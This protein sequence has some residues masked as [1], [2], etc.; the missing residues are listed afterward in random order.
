MLSIAD[1]N[2]PI[3][4]W[5]TG[6]ET[7]MLVSARNGADQLCLF[8]QWV[9]PGAGAPTH[10]HTVEEILTVLTGQAEMWVDDEHDLLT[11]G[12]SLLIP[13]HRRHGFKNV[14][15][16]LLRVHAV[17]AAP[18]FEAVMEGKADV[19]RRWLPDS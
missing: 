9:A 16:G 14:G 11:T 4:E 6:V 15:T 19:V 7:R 5:R 1:G 2:Y 10:T 8:E 18:V 13:A 12:Q 3:E 17:L